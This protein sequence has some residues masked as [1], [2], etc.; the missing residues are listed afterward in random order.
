MCAAVVAA[1]VL[2]QAS[3]SR[4][5]ALVTLTAGG[6]GP[7][8]LVLLHGYG[9]SAEDWVP[10][11]STIAWPQPGRLVFPQGPDLYAPLAGPSGG[12]AWWALDLQARI[13]LGA[14]MPDLSRTRPAGL[15]RATEAVVAQLGRLAQR[16]GGPVILGGFSQGAMVAS[17]VAY[18]TST[19]LAGLILLSGTPVDEA[20]WRPGYG[21]RR[22]LPTFV[23]HGRWDPVL[24]FAA[25][26]RMQREIAAAGGRVTW[27]PFDGRHEIPEDVVIALN[28]FL[29]GVR[30]TF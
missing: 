25:S 9:S 1:F 10:F 5:P 22:G 24:P 12:R 14:T 13:P 7:P 19:P 16:P 18:R 21:T 2:V 17:E 8:T 15:Q 28:E 27:H 30:G 4:V 11:A 29:A 23:A 20:T 6:D 3:C 26:E